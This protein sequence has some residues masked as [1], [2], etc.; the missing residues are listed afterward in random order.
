MRITLQ[1]RIQ[2]TVIS[3]VAV[4]S[5][6]LCFFFPARQR[7]QIQNSFVDATQALAVTVSLGVQIGLE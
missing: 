6:F 3:I 5:L 2:F 1:N 4:L 7:Q